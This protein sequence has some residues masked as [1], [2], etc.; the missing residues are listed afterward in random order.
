MSACHMGAAGDLTPVVAR[1]T[2]V[3]E[4]VVDLVGSKAVEEK[5]TA[6][7]KARTLANVLAAEND[8]KE[9][10]AA[11]EAHEARKVGKKSFMFGM[12]PGD[13]PICGPFE[14]VPPKDRKRLLGARV[15]AKVK[16][17]GQP[18]VLLSAYNP[19]PGPGKK[20]PAPAA[21]ASAT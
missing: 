13:K 2:E 18:V 16:I 1:L 5:V 10:V 6:K 4:A 11:G 12:A 9:K 8:W 3:L 17:G 19:G 14:T 21:E 15:G 20:A 7:R